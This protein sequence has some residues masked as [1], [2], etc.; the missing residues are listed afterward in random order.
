M[1]IFQGRVNTLRVF[2]RGFVVQVIRA[3]RRDPLDDVQRVAVEV[4]R[5]GRTSSDR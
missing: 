1:L 2:N 5:R 3:R 4:A